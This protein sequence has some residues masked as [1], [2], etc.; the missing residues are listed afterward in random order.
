MVDQDL[1]RLQKDLAVIREAAG[2]DLPFGREDV[3][4]NLAIVPL[5]IVAFLWSVLPHGLPAQWGVVPLLV[6]IVGYTAWLTRR[7]SRSS[8]RSSVRR[9]EY[10]VAWVLTGAFLVIGIVYRVWMRQSGIPFVYAQA[11]AIFL[12]GAGF[13]MPSVL[14]RRRIHLLGYAFPL[15]AAGLLIP[16][17]R[18]SPIAVFSLAM[19]VGAPVCAWIQTVQLRG[20][21]PNHAAD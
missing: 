16:A 18:I 13:I 11:G 12:M 15:M 19:A 5:S 2:I 21:M 14:D 17:V 8:G 6:F 1:D 10:R 20:V 9:R 4:L 3:W 7:Y